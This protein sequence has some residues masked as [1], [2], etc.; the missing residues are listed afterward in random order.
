MVFIVVLIIKLQ[1]A[2]DFMLAGN[3]SITSFVVVIV[4]FVPERELMIE[5]FLHAVIY[6]KTLYHTV[7]KCTI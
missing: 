7:Y 3:Q 5:L 1:L 2:I 4:I 6:H